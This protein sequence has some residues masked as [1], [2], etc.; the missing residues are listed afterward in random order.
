MTNKYLK[1][2]IN[3]LQIDQEEDI[4]QIR[5]YNELANELTRK[6]NE[7]AQVMNAL[8]KLHEDKA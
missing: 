3:N 7:R 6:I 8:K 4:K 5:R 1:E 2:T